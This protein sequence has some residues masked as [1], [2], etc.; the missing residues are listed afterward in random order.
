MECY[1]IEK[2]QDQ[3]LTDA[4]YWKPIYEEILRIKEQREILNNTLQAVNIGK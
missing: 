3:D 4:K 1:K 2:M